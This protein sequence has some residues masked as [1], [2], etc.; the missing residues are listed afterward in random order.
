MVRPAVAL[1]I[2]RR[3]NHQP[4][5]LDD[6]LTD[7]VLP[8]DLARLNAD[9]VAFLDRIVD[10][11]VVVQFDQ[12]FGMLLLESAHIPAELMRKKR[13]DAAQPQ[14][15]AE[16]DGQRAHR[17]LCLVQLG[18]HSG[19]PFEITGAGIRQR[20]A[21]GGADQK[22]GFE[23]VLQ[24]LHAFGD[25]RFGDAESAG[26]GHEAAAL[27]HA[28]EHANPGQLVHDLLFAL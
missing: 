8:T 18:H 6:R 11:I 20:Q 14:R 17:R 5:Q 28:N 24:L 19:A 26:G 3:R 21:A 1:E 25:D 13:C 27:D 22:L 23:P 9:V 12:Q 4:S 7:N 16:T 15:S 2:I 10:A